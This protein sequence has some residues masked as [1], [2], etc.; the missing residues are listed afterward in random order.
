MPGTQDKDQA[1]YYATYAWLTLRLSA[2]MK[3]TPTL[4]AV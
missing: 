4:P 3:D 1:N 2:A